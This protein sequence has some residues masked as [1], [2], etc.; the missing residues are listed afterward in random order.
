V[1]VTAP[2]R[3]PE[4]ENDRDLERRVAD[5]EAL[6]EEARRRARRRRIG[7][8][9]AL[10]VVA[11][12]VAGLSGLIGGGGRSAGATALAGDSGPKGQLSGQPVPLAPLPRGNEA[13]AFAFDP[14]RPDVVYVASRDA[15][16]G[17]YVFK[18]TDNGQHWRLTGA[19]GAG[20]RSDI[21]SL[22]AD[23]LHSG[24]L[25][26]GTN[27]AVYKT[28]DGGRSW[29][30][31][32]EGLFPS[33]PGRRVCSKD[34]YGAGSCGP[35]WFGT[36]G[37]PNWNR[38]NGWILDVAV[39]PSD[40]KVVYAAAA[41]GGVRK[42]ADG[43]RTWKTAFKAWRPHQGMVS[44]VAIAPT[45]PESIY[46]IAHGSTH[47]ATAIYKSTDAG[48]TWQPTGDTSTLPPSC[49]GDSQDSL[50]VDKTDPQTL[51]AA[52][53]DTVFAT[54]DGGASWQPTAHGLPAGDIT[55]LAVD[56]RSGSVYASA[57][58][59]L[60]RVNPTATYTPAGAIYKTTDHGRT[61]NETFSS[62]G[63]DKIA[64]DR[65][66]PSTIY[67]T[68]WAPADKTHNHKMRLLRSTDGG[69]TWSV[70]R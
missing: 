3:P 33:H 34:A 44:R 49:C 50:A 1:T 53:G 2:P 45:Q 55:S 8:G 17:V 43:G 15:N 30:P 42:S 62:I 60:N 14:R 69:H 48:K 47:G 51:Y 16:G 28:I 36:P 58:V 20:W 32:R 63:V 31:F 29:R 41:G 4:T 70:S 40:S 57:M 66:R 39:D 56:P 10:I 26:A 21:L 25:Y 59:D 54:A 37:K 65:A 13:S 46:A 68:G 61:W 12:M 18:T 11:T 67:A 27:T 5:L 64:I 7:I 38:D 23:P 22:T 6:I 52:V 19:R 9:L 24:T 35:L